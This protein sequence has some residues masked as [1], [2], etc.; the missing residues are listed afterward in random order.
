M[1][2]FV[3][4]NGSLCLINAAGQVLLGEDDGNR[5]VPVGALA[6]KRIAAA[7]HLSDGSLVLAGSGGVNLVAGT[8]KRND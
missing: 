1:A 8:E 5:F 3:T 4:A 7:T 2:G 6:Q